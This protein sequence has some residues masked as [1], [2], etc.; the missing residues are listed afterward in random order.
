MAE[1]NTVLTEKT[2]TGLDQRII[3]LALALRQP[4]FEPHNF[5]AGQHGAG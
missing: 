1:A 5:V 3:A 2:V 4:D